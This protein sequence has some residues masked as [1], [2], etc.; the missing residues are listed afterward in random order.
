[1]LLLDWKSCHK[2]G[3][4][5]EN[6]GD[7]PRHWKVWD[8]TGLPER[9]H[10]DSDGVVRRLL[11]LSVRTFLRKTPDRISML[12]EDISSVMGLWCVTSHALPELQE[13]LS[14]V[15]SVP[16]NFGAGWKSI[17]GSDTVRDI[18]APSERPVVLIPAGSES[19]MCRVCCENFCSEC[20]CNEVLILSRH[21]QRQFCLVLHAD[22]PKA[23]CK[24]E[25]ELESHSYD[26]RFDWDFWKVS[27][28]LAESPLGL[29]ESSLERL[30]IDRSV[31][32]EPQSGVSSVASSSST[33]IS[34]SFLSIG[35]GMK[36][37]ELTLHFTLKIVGVHYSASQDHIYCLHIL[38]SERKHPFSWKVTEQQCSQE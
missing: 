4:G 21:S 15:R 2:S 28:C 18:P 9:P 5:A 22:V 30:R 35:P 23:F 3:A 32:G 31:I 24:A 20:E 7:F 26:P 19:L 14:V 8:S 10:R 16:S 6:L 13:G 27:D 37:G 25:L 1:M 36:T 34:P 12:D 29:R 11:L 17:A 38:Y 33:F